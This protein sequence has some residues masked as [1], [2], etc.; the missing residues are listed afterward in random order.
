MSPVRDCKPLLMLALLSTVALS[1]SGE[2]V[3]EDAALSEVRATCETFIAAF[4]K[5]D[6]KAVAE[7]W[8]EK[9][10]YVDEAG[11]VYSGREAIEKAY[12]TF[13]SEHKGA[14][15][16]VKID[17]LR[18][19]SDGVAIEE[20]HA[21]VEPTP[22]GAPGS[23]KY[24]AVHNKVG[25]NWL[26]A[27]V[28]DTFVP[29]PSNYQSI[30]DL[31][32]LIGTWVAEEHGSKMVSVSRWVADKSFV[33]R[34]YTTTHHDGTK[35]SGVQIIGYNPQTKAVQSWN[36]SPGGGHAVGLWGPIDSGW[37]ATMH[38]VAGDGTVTTSI[39]VL[40]R[41]DDNAYSWK[42]IE[43]TAG[44]VALPDS[45]EVVVKRQTSSK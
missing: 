33:E 36:F 14:K 1:L 41:L 40:T 34:K 7:L 17:S 3:G 11:Q 10:E 4:N 18:L 9:G 20:G 21:E 31:E 38:G 25:D 29:K 2:A 39:N 43:R 35:Q 27:S 42:S 24:V 16:E 6:A 8:T 28:R 19:V 37:R 45:D 26:M 12:A 5:G 30:A 32:W 23:T 22:A 15:I 13:F 44:D